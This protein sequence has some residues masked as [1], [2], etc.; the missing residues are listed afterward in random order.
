VNP[1]FFKNQKKSQEGRND[2]QIILGKDLQMKAN[3]WA[4]VEPQA[5]KIEHKLN[6]IAR[7][8]EREQGAERNDPNWKMFN[9]PNYS[10]KLDESTGLGDELLELEQL[11]IPLGHSGSILHRR[12]LAKQQFQHDFLEEL[13]KSEIDNQEL[14]EAA[15]R[16]LYSLKNWFD[17][18]FLT[19]I[20]E[21]SK[22]FCFF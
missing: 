7:V 16:E 12:L 20:V 8:I 14:K 5:L 22:L 17:D 18:N 21:P 9:S 10:Q 6:T 11:V 3:R 2:N 13:V 19:T 15:F 4:L 1:R